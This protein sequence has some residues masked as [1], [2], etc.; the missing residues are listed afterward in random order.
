MAIC[1]RRKSQQGFQGGS[2]T[3]EEGVGQHTL[4]ARRGMHMGPLARKQVACVCKQALFPNG[5]D[6]FTG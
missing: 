6:R 3:R 5:S 4:P 1:E 2:P